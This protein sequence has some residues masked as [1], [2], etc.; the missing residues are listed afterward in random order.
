MGS[1]FIGVAVII[2]PDG[3]LRVRRAETTTAEQDSSVDR[4]LK[5][6]EPGTGA[7]LLHLTTRE[8]ETRLPLDLVFLRSFASRYLTELCRRPVEGVQQELPLIEPPPAGEI[9]SLILEAPPVT[10]LEYLRPDTLV[11]WWQDLDEYVRAGIRNHPGGA[12]EYLR[13]GNPLWRMVGR[14][15][16]HLAEN[17]KDPERPFAFLATY[18]SR[19]SAQGKLQHLPLSRALAEYSGARNRTALLSLLSPVQTAAER[20]PLLRQMLEDGDL[21]HPL[22]WSPAEAYSFLKETPALE[23]SGVIVRIPDWWKRRH[24]SRPVVKVTVVQPLLQ[25]QGSARNGVS[26]QD[27]GHY[28]TAYRLACV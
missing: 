15:T 8:L 20:S 19:L 14:V 11:G 24:G 22:A 7:G 2:S 28:G 21:Y 16:F 17:K 25:Y 10:G 9:A 4:V 26:S 6:F 12:R 13:E 1:L 23:E 5:A 3:H 27:Y 18:T